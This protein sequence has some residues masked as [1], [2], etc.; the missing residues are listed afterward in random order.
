MEDRPEPSPRADHGRWASYAGDYFLETDHLVQVAGISVGQIK[1]LRNAGIE[2][3][4]AL[5]KIK[6]HDA[7]V[8]KIVDRREAFLKA[9]KTLSRLV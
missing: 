1:K 4:A 7:L 9:L 2:T 3:M 5:A 6:N 8:D